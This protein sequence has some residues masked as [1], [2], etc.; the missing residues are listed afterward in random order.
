MNETRKC[1]Y[2]TAHNAHRMSVMR[3]SFVKIKNLLV[4]VHFIF[5][6][7][8]KL[9]KLLFQRLSSIQENK[10]HLSVSALSHQILDRIP[11]VEKLSVTGG[12]G[13]GRD[14]ATSDGIPWVVVEN[15]SLTVQCL[16]IKH[17][18][19]VSPLKYWN[20]GFDTINS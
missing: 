6:P 5:D 15:L 16:N 12:V 13:N 3:K 14:T 10:A 18:D 4:N 8:D 1:G 11:S 7:I 9:N 20:L 2:H 19:S 17:F